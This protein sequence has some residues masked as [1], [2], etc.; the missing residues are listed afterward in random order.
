MAK[1]IKLD[2]THHFVPE[3]IASTG[4]FG[5]QLHAYFRELGR[6]IKEETDEPLSLHYLHQRIAVAIQRGNAAP[7]LGTYPPGDTNPIF[8]K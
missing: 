6:R 7:V 1:Y 5:P 3:A 2:A 4:V 8:I